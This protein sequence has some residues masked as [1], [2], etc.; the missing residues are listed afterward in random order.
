MAKRYKKV[1]R[2]PVRRLWRRPDIKIYVGIMIICFFAAFIVYLVVDRGSRLIE[3][4]EDLSSKIPEGV[5]VEDVK[6]VLDSRDSGDEQANDEIEKLKKAYKEKLDPA[7]IERLK[8]QYNEM[9][10]DS[11]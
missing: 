4:V 5:T 11:R 7:E 3:K 10:K 8:K 9:K 6:K 2:K 1:R